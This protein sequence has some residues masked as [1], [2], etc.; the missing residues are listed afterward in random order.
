MSLY[1]IISQVIKIINFLDIG[2]PDGFVGIQ[3]VD[4]LST[5]L[6]PC[7]GGSDMDDDYEKVLNKK[8]EQHGCVKHK[9][10]KK[11]YDY[12][13]FFTK[14]WDK[15]AEQ[16]YFLLRLAHIFLENGKK[17]LALLIREKLISC[18]KSEEIKAIMIV[19]KLYCL[20]STEAK[21]YLEQLLNDPQFAFVKAQKKAWGLALLYLAAISFKQKEYKRADEVLGEIINDEYYKKHPIIYLYAKQLLGDI[22]YMQERYEEARVLY[23]RVL[24]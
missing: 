8:L 24:D 16:K 21:Q 1:K 15:V 20:T 23:D 7:I 11:T 2:R 3:W 4:S 10:G 12:R 17:D 19:L 14:H 5:Y 22:L 13:E 9:K 6:F 18:E